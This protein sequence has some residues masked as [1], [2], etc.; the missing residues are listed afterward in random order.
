MSDRPWYAH[1]HQLP[2]IARKRREGEVVWRLV[3]DLGRVQ[4]CD[5]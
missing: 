4:S 2:G 5:P 3:D 1:D